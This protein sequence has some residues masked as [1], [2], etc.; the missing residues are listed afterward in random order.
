MKFY[1]SIIT[2][3]LCLALNAQNNGV[4]KGRIFNELTNEAIPFARVLLEDTEIGA[5]SNLE[6]E[7]EIKNIKSGFYNLIVFFTGY[8]NA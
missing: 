4:I 2:V 1:F 5:T 3:F 6:G 8:N 7:F